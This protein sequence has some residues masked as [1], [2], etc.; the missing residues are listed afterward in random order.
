LGVE[1]ARPGRL[2]TKDISLIAALFSK[3][4]KEKGGG[5]GESYKGHSTKKKQGGGEK[6]DKGN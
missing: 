6:R 5:K 4:G 3:I 2:F 1:G